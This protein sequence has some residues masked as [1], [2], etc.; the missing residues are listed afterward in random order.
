[1]S[2]QDWLNKLQCASRSLTYEAEGL[3]QL[4]SS[5]EH[6]GN[7]AVADSLKLLAAKL[8]SLADD[9]RSATGTVVDTLAAR[10]DESSTNVLNAVMA[11]WK[12]GGEKK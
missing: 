1:M 4:A 10:A 2:D 11:G 9:I 6:V 12:L 7:V 5:F 3:Q 8:E